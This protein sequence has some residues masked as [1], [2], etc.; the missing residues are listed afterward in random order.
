MEAVYRSV[1]RACYA[2]FD[3]VTLRR[4]VAARVAP[5]VPYDKYAFSTCDPDTGL[6]T[7]T[8][9]DGVTSDLARAYV[10]RL[11][12]YHCACLTMDVP[13]TG[14]AVF[15]MLDLS[16]PTRDVLAAHGFD[17]QL[18]VSLTA[19]GRLVGTWCMM[20][21]DDAPPP[22]DAER[23]L[24][25]RLIPHVTRGLQAAAR[26][27]HGLAAARGG[28]IDDADHAP[29]I[30]V[31]D[32]RDR[33][34][35]R[36][37]LAAAWLDDLADVGLDMPDGLPLAVH[38][39]VVRLRAVRADVAADAHVRLRGRSGRWYVLRASLAE[40]D[41]YG[42][43]AIVV[44]VRP[45]VPREVATLLTR[46]Y[47]LSTREREIAAAVARGESTKEIAAALGLS[48]HTVLEH[49]DR[50]CGKIGVHGRKALIAKLFFDGYHPLL[51][52]SA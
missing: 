28:A 6:M 29:G 35:T 1:R 47:G 38:A 4:E 42:E 16:P 24:L 22:R 34:T 12:P 26:V 32:A 31:L 14:V 5:A 41:A 10:E 49:I 19:E 45:A 40:P 51:G 50:A 17:E 9:A 8:V 3:S 30:L 27:D 36:T 48:P 33:P 15:S 11:Y 18:Q 7:H 20:R 43:C 25:R 39:L 23:A 44:V 13:R 52:Q 21:A 2:G 46:L 37:P